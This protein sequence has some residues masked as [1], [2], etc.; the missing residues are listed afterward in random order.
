MT[1]IPRLRRTAL[2][3]VALVVLSCDGPVTVRMIDGWPVGPPIGAPMLSNE[4]CDWAGVA[5]KVFHRAHPGENGSGMQLYAEGSYVAGNGRPV[6]V[7][8]TSTIVVA[9]FTLGFG[10]QMAI[11]MICEGPGA[12]ATISPPD[13]SMIDQWAALTPRPTK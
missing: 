1:R 10:R 3:T 7:L 11:G 12:A 2:I 8:H 4:H 13:Q 9:V 6:S 5:R